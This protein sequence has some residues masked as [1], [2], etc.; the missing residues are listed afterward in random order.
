M[1]AV[2]QNGKLTAFGPKEDVLGAVVQAT[3]AAP[4]AASVGHIV[5]K[6]RA[7]AGAWVST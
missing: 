5:R 4:A 7:S 1:V 3:P 6:E 2:V